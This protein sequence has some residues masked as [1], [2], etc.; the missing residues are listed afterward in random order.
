M[1][2]NKGNWIDTTSDLFWIN[3][4][5]NKSA[6]RW[7]SQDEQIPTHHSSSFM[8]Q[9]TVNAINAL[10]ETLEA[11]PEDLLTFTV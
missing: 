4:Q 6:P 9:V 11:H 3:Q 8:R 2:A 5:F 1:I 7:K 10:A